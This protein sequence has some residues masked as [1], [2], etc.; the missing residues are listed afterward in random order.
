MLATLSDGSEIA[1]PRWTRNEEERLAFANRA[2]SR[3]CKGSKNR[4]KARERVRR[5][6]Q[7]IQGLRRAYLHKQSR[8]LIEKYDLI[9]FEKLD[10]RGLLRGKL[11]KSILDAAW[12]ELVWQ[13][14]YKAESAGKWAVPVN[15]KGTTQRCSRCGCIVPKKLWDRWHDCPQ[16]GLSIDRDHNSALEV[17]ALGE[18]AVERV[19]KCLPIR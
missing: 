3:K 8:K 5:V 18:S 7:R 12:G 19:T 16:C 15:P 9:A 17:K 10:I 4:C 6:C 2:L 1:N 11:A 14:T 13:I